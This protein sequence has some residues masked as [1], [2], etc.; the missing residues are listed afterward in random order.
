M[1]PA[2]ITWQMSTW[3]NTAVN[4]DLIDP[5]LTCKHI[6]DVMPNDENL[7]P[8]QAVGGGLC[9][10]FQRQF[11]QCMDIKSA[12]GKYSDI[13]KPF[14][15]CMAHDNDQTGCEADPNCFWADPKWFRF[16]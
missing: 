12:E 6:T 15:D 1:D 7:F 16:P 5:V 14:F 4:D 11:N 8:V 10:M 9:H 3:Y 13:S 2:N